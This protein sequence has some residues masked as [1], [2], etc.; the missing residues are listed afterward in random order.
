MWQAGRLVTSPTFMIRHIVDRVGAGDAFMA[1]LIYGL[2]SYPDD[3]QRVVDFAAA[4]AVFK[5]TI[6][7]DANLAGR[8]EIAQLL[9]TGNGYDII[10]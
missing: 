6:P 8:E 4:C 9:V 10:R 3:P 5:H 2:V 1:G 7:G